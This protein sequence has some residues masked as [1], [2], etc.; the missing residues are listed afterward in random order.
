MAGKRRP[1]PVTQAAFARL[2]GYSGAAITKAKAAQ[3]VHVD[4]RGRVPLDH[5]ANKEFL[6]AARARDGRGTARQTAP[7]GP[8]AD[9]KG[10]AR[11]AEA[12]RRAARGEALPLTIRKLEEE[13][14]FKSGRADLGELE[15][16]ERRRQLIPR[17]L[18][19]K[20]FAVLN[21]GLRAHMLTLPRRAVPHLTGL[22]ET[23]KQEEA[24]G[25]LEAEMAAAIEHV[26]KGVDDGAR[27]HFRSLTAAE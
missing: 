9:G 15:L 24:L 23:G 7:R 6:A 4:S 1:Q 5:P 10:P 16:A 2:A 13:I 18:V 22:V 11:P 12:P 3:R 20:W 17:D 14:R 19:K 27:E 21:A 26:L 25:Y 8:H